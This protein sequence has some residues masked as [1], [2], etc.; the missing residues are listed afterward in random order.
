M[1]EQQPKHPMVLF[2]EQIYDPPQLSEF[3]AV[4]PPNIRP[5]EFVG[6][7]V[8]A[9][10]EKPELL[11]YSRQSLFNALMRAAKDGLLPD[12]REGWILPFKENFQTADGQWKTRILA[13]WTR[14]PIG[15]RKMILNKSRIRL[16]VKVVYPEDYFEYQEGDEPRIVHKPAPHNGRT[17][18]ITAVYSIARDE[19]GRIIGRDVMW[20]AEIDQ[21]KAKAKSKNVWDDPVFYPE[22][23]MK[24][25][26]HHH[27]KSLPTSHEVQFEPIELGRPEPGRIGRPEEPLQE[28]LPSPDIFPQ[29]MP[30]EPM[31]KPERSV[32]NALDALA[33]KEPVGMAVPGKEEEAKKKR[34]RRTKEQIEHD[35][36]Q[37][38]KAKSELAA[39]AAQDA[40]ERAG[41]ADPFSGP[42]SGSSTTTATVSG[43]GGP[44]ANRIVLLDGDNRAYYA[45]TGEYVNEE[46]SQDYDHEAEEAK[47]NQAVPAQEEKPA[48]QVAH[49]APGAGGNS[50]APPASANAGASSKNGGGGHLTTD[51]QAT[52]AFLREMSASLQGRKITSKQQYLDFLERWLEQAGDDGNKYKAVRE[53]VGSTSNGQEFGVR[54]E[55][56]RD[57]ATRV[58]EARKRP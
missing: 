21:I 28:L 39:K 37:I 34:T 33:G 7:V 27:S 41:H 29:S 42:A 32:E 31:H 6:V 57:V 2:R 46:T 53:F 20:K 12:G 26:I 10:Y 35:N 55:E 18:D 40:A 54:A 11:G 49:N 48:A 4:L 58:Q 45:D 13:R 43:G 19:N 15:E 5:E 16:D 25:V 17:D 30:G 36:A 22:M 1:N 9:V 8:T 52:F 14:S 47:G 51:Q 44:G 38:E 24:T 56:I 23:A 3:R 50:A